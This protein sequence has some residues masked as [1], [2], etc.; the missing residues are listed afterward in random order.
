[1]PGNRFGGAWLPNRIESGVDAGAGQDIEQQILAKTPPAV[2]QWVEECR[3]HNPNIKRNDLVP[4]ELELPRDNATFEKIGIC[5]MLKK[6][7][8]AP[9]DQEIIDAYAVRRRVS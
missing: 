1:M 2:K 3:R 8:Q 7:P 9:N 5:E 4:V 6:W